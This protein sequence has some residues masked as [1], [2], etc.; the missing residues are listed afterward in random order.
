MRETFDKQF[1]AYK[2][3]NKYENLNIGCG[4]DVDPQFTNS[5]KQLAGGA[6][7]LWDLE[8]TPSPFMAN[9][10]QLIVASH[11]LEHT[12]KL[13]PLMDEIYRILKPNGHLIIFVPYF[14]T[15][16][17][18]ANPE[19]CRT[20]SEQSWMFFSQD[21]NKSNGACCYDMGFKCNYFTEAVILEP[22][23]EFMKDPNLDHRIR[24]EWNIIREM[25]AV[26][27]K[28]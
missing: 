12:Y 9:T 16:A 1:G 8:H 5:D 11:V 14:M 24:H 15:H 21:M 10:F 3:T 17:A 27:R 13:M 4:F 6:D 18:I 25:C 28:V 7:V 19:H 22:H 2:S 23:P 26:L 20:F